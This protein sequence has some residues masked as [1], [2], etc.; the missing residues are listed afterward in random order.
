[1]GVPNNSNK[2]VQICKNRLTL[3]VSFV[4]PTHEIELEIRWIPFELVLFRDL[5]LHVF[6]QETK[7]GI[8]G[9]ISLEGPDEYDI[10]C[11]EA[12]ERV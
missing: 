5:F 12:M 7:Y 2:K 10:L 1:M 6:A 11:S 3:R 9:P 4:L 8:D